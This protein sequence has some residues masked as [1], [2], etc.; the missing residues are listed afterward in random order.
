[1]TMR[2]SF[3]M[4]G[5]GMGGCILASASGVGGATGIGGCIFAPASSA[6]AGAAPKSTIAMTSTPAARRTRAENRITPPWTRVWPMTIK[7]GALQYEGVL[8]GGEVL[9]V[10]RSRRY[11]EEI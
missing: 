5:A 8:A 1:M 4:A 3:A 7:E 2:N 9:T 11:E 6:N 10:L